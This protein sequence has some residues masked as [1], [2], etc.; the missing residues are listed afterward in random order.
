MKSFM[1]S[2][3]MISLIGSVLCLVGVGLFLVARKSKK[4]PPTYDESD[5]ESSQD[6]FDDKYKVN[7]DGFDDFE[8]SSQSSSNTEEESATAAGAKNWGQTFTGLGWRTKSVPE[9]GSVGSREESTVSGGN[10]NSVADTLSQTLSGLS[11]VAEDAIFPVS[12]KRGRSKR[13]GNRGDRK[14]SGD[15]YDSCKRQYHYRSGDDESIPIAESASSEFGASSR[16]NISVAS[17]ASSQAD[18]SASE[19]VETVWSDHHSQGSSV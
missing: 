9:S 7:F 1:T 12:N 17:G 18:S 8:I 5:D 3:L 15:Q 14:K 11:E 2:P 10:G 19:E 4:S 16:G 13:H 6:S